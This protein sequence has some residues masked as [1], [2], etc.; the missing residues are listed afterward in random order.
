MQGG[1]SS[2]NAAVAGAILGCKVGY[3]DLPKDWLEGL[4]PQQVDWLNKK[5]NCLLDMMAL[6]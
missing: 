5:I 1:H 4:L 3:S 6:P 2:C